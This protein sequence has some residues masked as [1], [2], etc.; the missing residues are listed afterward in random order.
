MLS[1]IYHE[2]EVGFMKVLLLQDVKGTGKA[3][4]VKNV[5][6]GYARN[7]LLPR[8]LAVVA[9]KKTLK[10]LDVQREIERRRRER[11]T[12][13][14]SALA[15]MLADVTVTFKARVGEQHRLYGSITST[16]IAKAVSAEIQQEIDKRKVLLDEP[17]KSLGEFQVPIKVAADLTPTVRVIIEAEGEEDK[18]SKT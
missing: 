9:T 12:D 11:A 5:A 16:D 1:G 10:S 8:N 18:E 2:S 17:L 15:A 7:Y 4:E 13:E 3:G 14:A 6:D